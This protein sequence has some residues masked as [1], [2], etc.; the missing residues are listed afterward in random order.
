MTGLLDAM[1]L[2]V[3]DA[4]EIN[5]T[6]MLSMEGTTG[7][8]IGRIFFSTDCQAW[9]NV[10]LPATNG[11]G[12]SLNWVNIGWSGAQNKLIAVGFG[13]FE[14][15]SGVSGFWMYVTI[16]TNAG[17][18]W[19]SPARIPDM[20]SS[21]S[22][23][24]PNIYPIKYVNQL[25]MWFLGGDTTTK[26]FAKSVDGVTWVNIDVNI[27]SS[28]SRT[29]V[30]SFSYDDIQ[31][32]LTASI[33]ALVGALNQEN[34]YIYSTDGNVWSAYIST[35][36]VGSGVNAV[37]A[38]TA[39]HD[40]MTIGLMQSA[41]NVYDGSCYIGYS[42]NAAGGVM[43]GSWD[44]SLPYMI[45]SPTII[46]RSER[47]EKYHAIAIFH[48][49][50]GG[51]PATPTSEDGRIWSLNPQ[52]TAPS[53][54]R[55]AQV[56][57]VQRF[58][59]FVIVGFGGSSIADRVKLSVDGTTWSTTDPRVSVTS[60]LVSPSVVELEPG[61]T[62]QLTA[63]L[64]PSNATNKNVSWASDNP[65]VATVS[66]T[67]F[68]TALASGTAIVTVTT[69]DG[70]YTHQAHITVAE[71]PPPTPGV[72][73]FL[74]FATAS[75]ANVMP[76]SQYAAGAERALGHVPRS[77]SSS[78]L[79]NKANRQGSNMAAAIGTF[80]S[81]QGFD[82]KDDT[83]IDTLAYSLGQAIKAFIARE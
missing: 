64:S 31:N 44:A 53:D 20:V 58:G 28:F 40:R 24:S 6:F 32:K 29:L 27:P 51:R 83:D 50:S 1:Y 71:I 13:P 55:Y 81:N 16:S 77:I 41:T 12:G 49:S 78:A 30:T 42:D 75:T 2:A 26:K 68:V 72:N 8:R 45:S 17:L 36:G 43:Q 3:C 74:P 25:N 66:S 9:S 70:G 35:K 33:C 52:A 37:Y 38:G 7:S 48:S 15:V 67:G 79:A 4:P 34:G 76:Q 23:A 69:E 65:T 47:T 14:T 11:A 18:T 39:S 59:F 63:T 10:Q 21:G 56:C 61:Q 19:S 57:D 80:I 22:S 46:I 62:Q 73:E 82:A 54:L 5:K 60:V